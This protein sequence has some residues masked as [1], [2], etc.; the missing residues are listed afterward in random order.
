MADESGG[1][2]LSA[3]SVVYENCIYHADL[4]N[5]CT[6]ADSREETDNAVYGVAVETRNN[7]SVTVKMSAEFGGTAYPSASFVLP[8]NVR[9]VVDSDVASELIVLAEG[10]VC[11]IGYKFCKLFGSLDD[12]GIFCCTATACKFACKFTRPDTA[13]FTFVGEL[14]LEGKTKVEIS[15]ILGVARTTYNYRF[16]KLRKALAKRLKK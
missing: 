16:D 6:F 12:V 7:V 3:R 15:S 14:M 2:G 8:A 4:F 10:C 11:T 9:G 13:L 1:V 5:N